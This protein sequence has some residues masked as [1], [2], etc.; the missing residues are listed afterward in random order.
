M[1]TT[2]RKAAMQKKPDRESPHV[3]RP[4]L[5]TGSILGTPPKKKMIL[6]HRSVQRTAMQSMY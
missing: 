6:V 2:L 1:S 3:I 4:S 5:K